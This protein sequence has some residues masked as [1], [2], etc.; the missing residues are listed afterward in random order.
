MAA[1]LFLYHFWRWA[2]DQHK[3]EKQKNDAR[4]NRGK[5]DGGK[6]GEEENGRRL[7]LYE[8]GLSDGQIGKIVGVARGSITS[9]RKCRN[10]PA[11]FDATNLDI[12]T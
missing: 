5:F 8:L 7:E 2:H 11:N 4:K 3:P 1:P 10:L 12:K 6:I 9:W